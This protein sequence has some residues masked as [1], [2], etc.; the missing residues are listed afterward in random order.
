M[1]DRTVE[2]EKTP[3]AP[4]RHPSGSP[5]DKA[6][7]TQLRLRHAGECGSE[8]DLL[9]QYEPEVLILVAGANPLM[10]LLPYQVWVSSKTP[11]G[12][13]A[14]TS[15]CRLSRQSPATGQGHFDAKPSLLGG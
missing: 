2:S 5:D 1:S 8:R 9:D 12:R 13:T 6:Q 10:R 7:L 3:V 11:T 14:V 4:T 15:V